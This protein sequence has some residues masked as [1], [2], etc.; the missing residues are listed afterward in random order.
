MPRSFYTH[1]GNSEYYEMYSTLKEVVFLQNYLT[2]NRVPYLFCTADMYFKDHEN[3]LRHAHDVSMNVLYK[4][5]DWS[6]WFLF[7]PGQGPNQTEGPRGFYQWAIESKY[8]I[9]STHPLEQAHIDASVLMQEK[10]NE[11]VEKHIQ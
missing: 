4:Q 5:I 7:P 9:G 6:N 11:L 8:Q 3:Y 1:V 10:F 2:S